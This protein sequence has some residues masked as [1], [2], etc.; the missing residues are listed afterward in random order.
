MMA[1]VNCLLSIWRWSFTS[2]DDT[3]GAAP[4]GTYVYR[5]VRAF[6]EEQPEEQLLLQQGL[7]TQKVFKARITPGYLTIYERDEVTVVA[8]SDHYY[9]NKRFRVT[10]VRPAVMNRRDPRA[11]TLLTLLRSERAHVRQ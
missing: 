10:N 6:L 7:E 4:T 5:D 11:Y 2:D 9:Y 1:G 8:P 3:G